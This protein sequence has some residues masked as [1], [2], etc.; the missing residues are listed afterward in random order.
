[1]GRSAKIIVTSLPPAPRDV[2]EAAVEL[3]GIPVE[4]AVFNGGEEYLPSSL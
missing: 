2:V 1:M 3:G 4:E